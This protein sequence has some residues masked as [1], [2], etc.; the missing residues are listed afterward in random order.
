MPLSDGFLEMK[1]NSDRS[2]ENNVGG[3]GGMEKPR[4]VGLGGAAVAEP[5]P[6]RRSEAAGEGESAGWDDEERLVGDEESVDWMT[7][8]RKGAQK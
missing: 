4:E 5:F 7:R 1:T 6:L 8:S 3:V 2:A